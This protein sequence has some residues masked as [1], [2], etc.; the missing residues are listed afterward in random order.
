MFLDQLTQLLELPSDQ[1]FKIKHV[2]FAEERPKGFTPLSMDIVAYRRAYSP[3]ILR[4][5]SM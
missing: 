4:V 3:G 2:S 5:L 1:W